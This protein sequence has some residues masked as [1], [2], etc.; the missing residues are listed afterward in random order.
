MKIKFLF[1]F[2]LL[3]IFC[4]RNNK[5]EVEDNNKRLENLKEKSLI[6]VFDNESK[7][8]DFQIDIFTTDD[9]L[10]ENNINF[11]DIKEE[12]L[13]ICYDDGVGYIDLRNGRILNF[14]YK[15]NSGFNSFI[16]R[17][18]ELFILSKNGLI[19]FDIVNK[20]FTIAISNKNFL[21]YPL[22]Y[23]DS[24][25][26]SSKNEI[27]LF[28]K[29]KIVKSTNIGEEIIELKDCEGDFYILSRNSLYK[30]E[31]E[32]FL[33]ERVIDISSFSNI[34]DFCLD[35]DE[36]IYLGSRRLILASRG[37]FKNLLEFEKCFINFLLYSKRDDGI[38][39]GTSSGAGIYDIESGNYF[40]ILSEYKVKEAFINYILEDGD[41]LWIATKGWGVIKF[42]KIEGY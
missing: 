24:I 9:G 7:R 40:Y 35:K 37:G 39:I 2:I 17:N 30:F 8:S 18:N 20:N 41:R 36:N 12:K 11:L 42:N 10:L 29:S 14:F 13:W 19:K 33:I 23:K 6:K 28:E 15:T 5:K 3:L 1:I 26:L 21:K 34:E 16:I 4:A 22:N 25:L 27:F 32:K 31:V 38:V